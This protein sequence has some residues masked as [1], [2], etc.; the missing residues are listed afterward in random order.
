[1]TDAADSQWEVLVGTVLSSTT[2]RQVL[3][4]QHYAPQGT[5]CGAGNC[6]RTGIGQ[7]AAPSQPFIVVQVGRG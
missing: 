1:M 7:L 5:E 6:R 2:C 4:A 3:W